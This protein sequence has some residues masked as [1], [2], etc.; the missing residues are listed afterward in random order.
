LAGPFLQGIDFKIRKR[1]IAEAKVAR[2]SKRTKRMC[3]VAHRAK[4]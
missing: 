3:A 1:L 4:E 2:R